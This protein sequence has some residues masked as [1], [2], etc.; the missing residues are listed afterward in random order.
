MK[1]LHLCSISLAVLAMMVLSFICF[2][3]SDRWIRKADMPTPRGALATCVVD[4]KS[5]RLVVVKVMMRDHLSR[6]MILSPITG[7]SEPACRNQGLH[8]PAL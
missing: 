6:S 2:Q 3:Q 5:L 8:L 4:G 7:Q 1:R